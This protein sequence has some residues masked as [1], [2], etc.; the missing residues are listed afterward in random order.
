MLDRTRSNA[1]RVRYVHEM[2]RELKGIADSEECKV[3]AHLLE[4]AYLE[5]GDFLRDL[6]AANSNS[7]PRQPPE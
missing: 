3:L 5:S 6:H 4:M 7:P 1:E 2:L